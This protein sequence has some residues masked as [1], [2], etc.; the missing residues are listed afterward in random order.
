MPTAGSV[1]KAKVPHQAWRRIRRPESDLSP[2]LSRVRDIVK[3]VDA[4]QL[5]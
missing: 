3:V 2:S 5:R 1:D 4:S